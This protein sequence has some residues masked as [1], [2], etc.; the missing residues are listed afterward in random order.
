MKT[1]ESKAVA[2]PVMPYRQTFHERLAA[3]TDAVESLPILR[4]RV[5]WLDVLVLAV[6]L[7]H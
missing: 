3:F 2:A 6:F 4:P 5:V 1:N 7:L